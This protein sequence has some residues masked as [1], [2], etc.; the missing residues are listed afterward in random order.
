MSAGMVVRQT[1]PMNGRQRSAKG[2]HRHLVLGYARTALDGVRF[3]I[4]SH[5]GSLGLCDL[6]MAV[7]LRLGE[8][9]VL[10]VPLQAAGPSVGLSLR[11]ID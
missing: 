9:K 11:H 1:R 8:R 10:L 6:H 4:V 3:G 5:V 7:L 2:V